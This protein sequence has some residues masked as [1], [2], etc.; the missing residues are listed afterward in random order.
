MDVFL[1]TFFFLEFLNNINLEAY[2][3][4]DAAILFSESTDIYSNEYNNSIYTFFF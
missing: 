3:A 1:N 2:T 4:S